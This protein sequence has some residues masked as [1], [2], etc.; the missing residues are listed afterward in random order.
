M[1][2]SDLLNN[3]SEPLRVSV[4]APYGHEVIR[5]ECARSRAFADLLGQKTL[6]RANVDKLK[7]FGYKFEVIEPE[8][9]VL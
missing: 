8:R 5:P 4:Q 7:E 2:L 6:T 3:T 9:K 1:N